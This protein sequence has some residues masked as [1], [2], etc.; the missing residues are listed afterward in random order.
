M[1][2]AWVNRGIAQL[3]RQFCDK[4]G[5]AAWIGVASLDGLGGTP[6]NGLWREGGHYEPMPG[7]ALADG[8]VWRPDAGRGEPEL[9]LS[10]TKTGYRDIFERFAQRHLGAPGLTGANVQIDHVFPKKA[11]GLGDLTYVRML[12]IPPESNMRAGSTLERAMKD[13]NTEHGPRRKLTRMATYFSIG[14][15]TGFVGYEQMPEDERGQPNADLAHALIAYL[16]GFGLPADVV[17]A[18]DEQLLEG[19]AAVLR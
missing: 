15:A 10:P 17:T 4:H 19:T 16:R 14:K 6:Q 5:N 7:L 11:G 2:P 8:F 12:A 9:W 13:R 3:I 18:L 1:Y